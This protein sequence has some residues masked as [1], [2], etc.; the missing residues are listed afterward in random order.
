M[1]EGLLW[2]LPIIPTPLWRI[3][4]AWLKKLGT[5]IPNQIT[6]SRSDASNKTVEQLLAWTSWWSESSNVKPEKVEEAI[7]KIGKTSNISSGAAWLTQWL[8]QELWT[9]YTNNSEFFWNSAWT[10]WLFYSQSNWQSLLW[11]WV[12]LLSKSF[13]SRTKDEKDQFYKWFNDFLE[14]KYKNKWSITEDEFKTLETEMSLEWWKW[15]NTKNKE[16]IWWLRVG[17]NYLQIKDWKI[18][19][20]PIFTN[21]KISNTTPISAVTDQTEKDNLDKDTQ[22]IIDLWPTWLN[23][24][25]EFLSRLKPEQ[26]N[27]V[28]IAQLS[29]LK[30]EQKAAL[31]STNPDWNEFTLD[32]NFIETITAKDLPKL[33]PAQ[34]TNIPTPQFNKLLTDK[35][36]LINNFSWIQLLAM[37]Q[38]Q[39]DILK[40]RTWNLDNTDAIIKKA[41]IDLID[42][43]VISVTSL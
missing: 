27:A 38:Q 20:K 18:D 12:D 7:E 41:K 33:S 39:K 8:N 42:A 1:T 6:Q 25:E 21:K 2:N 19:K 13:S 36:D 37:N 29:N 35:P 22:F 32:D 3:S 16:L 11:K 9:K 10:E 23:F 5:E 34:I 30:P 24:S 17:D 26:K 4:W 15:I 31:I 14:A 40:K 43:K 28:S